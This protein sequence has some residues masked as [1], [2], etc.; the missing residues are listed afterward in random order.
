MLILLRGQIG[1]I[2]LQPLQ[3]LCKQL[4]TVTTQKRLRTTKKDGP[5]A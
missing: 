3:N 5:I 4:D 2:Q 1:Y